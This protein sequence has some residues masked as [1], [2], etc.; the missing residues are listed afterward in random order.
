MFAWEGD[1]GV[2]DSTNGE[3]VQPH[4]GSHLDMTEVLH[5]GCGQIRRSC[6]VWPLYTQDYHTGLVVMPAWLRRK[7]KNLHPG[8]TRGT[9]GVDFPR[10]DIVI[11]SDSTHVAHSRY[12]VSCLLCTPMDSDGLRTPYSDDEATL[13]WHSAAALPCPSHP[14][15]SRSSAGFSTSLIMPSR[16]TSRTSGQ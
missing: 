1:S 3:P 13:M 4:S 10:R 8:L 7:P 2:A 14:A 5:H 6:Y 16:S 12:V 15:P 9:L 11:T